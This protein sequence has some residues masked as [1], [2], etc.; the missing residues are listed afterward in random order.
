MYYFD[1]HGILAND[2]EC[3]WCHD[4]ELDRETNV[5]T[6]TWANFIWALNRFIVKKRACTDSCEHRVT[7]FPDADKTTRIDPGA[8]CVAQ[9]ID[10]QAGARIVWCR[11]CG[12][13][14][15]SQRSIASNITSHFDADVKVCMRLMWS[16]WREHGFATQLCINYFITFRFRHTHGQDSDAN[17]AWC[18]SCGN[19]TLSMRTKSF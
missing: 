18:S 12:V 15:A 6:Q 4:W 2:I 5:G 17:I 16:L 3:V 11:H 10:R 13:T 14:M 7:R 9:R 8:A 1:A 19:S